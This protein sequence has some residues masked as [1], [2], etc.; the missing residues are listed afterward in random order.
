[1]TA[2]SLAIY[3]ARRRGGGADPGQAIINTAFFHLDAE[4]LTGADASNQSAWLDRIAAV[5]CT[6]ASDAFTLE[7][8]EMNGLPVGR[9][10]GKQLAIPNGLLTGKTELTIIY[11]GK[12]NT[13]FGGAAFANFGTDAQS[14]HFPYIDGVIYEDFGSTT[15]KTCGDYATHGMNVNHI[16]SM[17][18]KA[19]LWDLRVDGSSKFNTV[20]NTVGVNSTG[21]TIGNATG[22]FGDLAKVMLF[23]TY[24][25]D[26]DMADV[27]STL[28]ARYAL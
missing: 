7:T 2:L 20:T 13:A 16:G 15:R 3:A 14:N 28:A 23:D 12:I 26:V 27:E 11:V 5:N 19:S 6:G 10:T 18:S 4:D 1:M 24:I 8:N 17:R 21:L 25:S 9:F 22:W